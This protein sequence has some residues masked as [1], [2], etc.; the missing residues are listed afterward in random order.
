MKKI[1]ESPS[2]NP[3]QSIIA[4]PKPDEEI[5][6]NSVRDHKSMHYLRNGRE[7]L[8]IDQDNEKMM[9]RI[10][11]TKPWEQHTKEFL[12]KEFLKNLTVERKQKI[13]SPIPKGFATLNTVIDKNLNV[14]EKIKS[15]NTQKINLN[16]SED[17]NQQEQYEKRSRSVLKKGLSPLKLPEIAQRNRIKNQSI[18]YQGNSEIE[19]PGSYAGYIKNLRSSNLYDYQVTQTDVGNTSPSKYKEMI[20]KN[21]LRLKY[22]LGEP[23]S[24]DRVKSKSHL[25]NYYANKESSEFN[26]FMEAQINKKK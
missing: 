14:F 17:K 19:S 15:R 6:K 7:S 11:E 2:P 9:K 16:F 4:K 22:K 8:R 23:M 12:D 1:H 26:S 25:V 13:T 18:K 3:G 20:A 21:H 5:T 24:S 10:F